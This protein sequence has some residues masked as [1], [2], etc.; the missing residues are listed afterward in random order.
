MKKLIMLSMLVVLYGTV[1]KA[2]VKIGAIGGPSF[3]TFT[4]SDV[5]SWGGLYSDPKMMVKFHFGLFFNYPINDQFSLESRVIYSA[6]GPKYSGDYTEYDDQTFELYEGTMTVTKQLSYLE[7]PVLVNYKVAEKVVVFV[8]P[9]VGFRLAAKAKSEF[10]GTS[11]GGS[12]LSTSETND[13]KEYY[14]GIDFGLLLGVGYD[15][16]ETLGLN[17]AF[18]PGLSKIAHYEY[19][20][21]DTKY[22]VKNSSFT[23][24]LRYIFRQ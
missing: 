5:E 3:V 15:L 11:Q 7:I 24:S 8:G 21:T 16:S 10:T 23:I 12:N 13:Q 4:G 20:G 1:A 17:I 18:N 19:E 9:Q 22:D 6:K 2:Q 14:T